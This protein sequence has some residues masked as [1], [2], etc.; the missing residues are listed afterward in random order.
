MMNT[1]MGT[2]LAACEGEMGDTKNPHRAKRVSRF[3]G[4][5]ALH[6]AMCHFLPQKPGVFAY[7]AKVLI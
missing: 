7:A 2:A 1:A 6:A 4:A 5:Y 3:K